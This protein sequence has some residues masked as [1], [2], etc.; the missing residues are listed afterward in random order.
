MSVATS[1]LD[2]YPP[3]AH[4]RLKRSSKRV[5][6]EALLLATVIHFLVLT[7]APPLVAPDVSFG[8][9]ELSMVDLPPEIHIPPPPQTIARPAAPVIT[10]SAEVSEDITI[11]PTTFDAQPASALP[12]PPAAKAGDEEVLSRAPVFTPYTVAPTLRN[13]E[14]VGTQLVKLYPP[15]LRDAGIGGT[16]LVWFFIDVEG[17]VQRTLVHTPSSYEGFNEVALEIAEIMQFTPARNRDKLVP[18]W[19][20]IP[21]TF[22]TR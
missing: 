21:I 1:T 13:R 20:A 16:V 12:P 14:E 22:T 15:L 5:F 4:D 8:V 18:V 7:F 10:A 11:A 9:V 2:L 6:A 17:K 3:T 19:V